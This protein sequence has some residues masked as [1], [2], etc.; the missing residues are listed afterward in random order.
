[1]SGIITMRAEIEH[2]PL[3]GQKALAARVQIHFDGPRSDEAPYPHDQ[4]GAARLVE[5]E[6]RG[7]EPVDHGALAGEHLSHVDADGAGDR[8]ELIGVAHEIG[9]FRAPDLILARQAVDVRTRAANQLALDDGD[10]LARFRRVPGEIFAAFSA[11]DDERV[12]GFRFG[13]GEDPRSRHC[14]PDR[15]DPELVRNIKLR[16]AQS[17]RVKACA[18]GRRSSACSPARPAWIMARQPSPDR[19]FRSS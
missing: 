13:H 19:R 8:A 18:L 2:D 1:M 16:H 17:G 11:A 7:D 14:A 15:R 12:T 3:G 10:A 6:M 9:D 5:F 4:F